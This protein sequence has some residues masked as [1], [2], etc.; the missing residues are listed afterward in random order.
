MNMHVMLGEK[1]WGNSIINQ[2]WDWFS[3]PVDDKNK[4]MLLHLWCHTPS[5]AR[6]TCITKP[7]LKTLCF[8]KRMASWLPLFTPFAISVRSSDFPMLQPHWWPVFLLLTS[9]LPYIIS[10]AFIP[11]SWRL[12][13]NQFPFLSSLCFISFFPWVPMFH[14]PVNSHFGVIISWVPGFGFAMSEVATACLLPLFWVL[15]LFLRCVWFSG[16]YVQRLFAI[17]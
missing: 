8:W 3:Y 9:S 14:G 13:S 1:V 2:A 15:P 17:V 11:F 4:G 7:V 10:S 5:S 12:I 16:L 6:S